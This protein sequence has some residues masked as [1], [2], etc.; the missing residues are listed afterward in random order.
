MSGLI[1]KLFG[2]GKYE[3]SPKPAEPPQKAEPD[4]KP[5][6]DSAPW[7]TTLKAFRGLSEHS[8]SG[9]KIVS[10]MHKIAGLDPSDQKPSTAWCGS[11]QVWN[12]VQNLHLDRALFPKDAAWARSWSYKS[13]WGTKLSKPQ[14]GAFVN[15]E[16]NAPGG[17]SHITIYLYT[18]ANGNWVCIGGN[19]SDTIKESAYDP[20][21][22]IAASWPPSTVLKALGLSA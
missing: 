21:D 4:P 19:Q 20:K 14:Y 7:V 18:D 22:L 6:F 13:G 5:P 3:G 11:C 16:R 8:A 2:S 9:G 10:E 17:D 15:L 1:V 12:F